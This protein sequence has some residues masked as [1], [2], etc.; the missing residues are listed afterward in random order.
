MKADHDVKVPREYCSKGSNLFY[1]EKRVLPYYVHSPAE[2]SVEQERVGNWLPQV[3]T[4]NDL[5]PL[6][7]TFI[8]SVSQQ[9]VKSTTKS[10]RLSHTINSTSS[11]STLFP[12][13]IANN[14]L[15]IPKIPNV[16]LFS[17]ALE[18]HNKHSHI[19]AGRMFTDVYVVP[20]SYLRMLWS[21]F[22]PIHLVYSVNS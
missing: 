21:F 1:A 8:Q 7:A 10:H 15:K 11:G 2:L 19:T 13:T 5:D 6:Q 14:N 12:A 16:R 22:P 9:L 20:M 4:G 18:I 17:A 3:V